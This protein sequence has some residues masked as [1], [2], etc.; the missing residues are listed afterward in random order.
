M[1]ALRIFCDTA[2]AAQTMAL[3]RHGTE[4]H[5]LVAAQ[6]PAASVL[7]KSEA[8]PEI[9][10][11]EVAFGQPDVADILRAT[12]LKWLHLT[13][14]GYT[15]YDTTDFRA[16]MKQRGIMVTNSSSVYA[17]AC[18]EHVMAFLLAQARLLQRN[19]S[20]RCANGGDEWNALREA[21][22]LLIGQ[23]VLIAGYGAIAERLVEVLAP[24]RMDVVAMRRNPR[25]DEPIRVVRLEDFDAE[26]A[27]ADHVINILPDNSQSRGYFDAKRIAQMNKNA[28]FFKH[29]TR[30]YSGPRCT[31]RRARNRSSCSC[32]VGRY[33]SRTA[34]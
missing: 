13:S 18:V 9:E 6:K 14:A 15:R 3:L 4:G 19:L 27:T 29:R 33:R 12:K 10:N 8:G 34:C 20:S 22:R 31:G 25:G 17:E 5:V 30:C 11:V 26:L 21:S 1:K 16:A 23:R 28:V 24:F 32:M 7:G 2:F